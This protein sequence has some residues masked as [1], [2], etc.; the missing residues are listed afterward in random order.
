LKFNK[1]KL[2]IVAIIP[3]RSGSKSIKDKNIVPFKGKPLVAWSILHCLKC[4]VFDA[5]YFSTDSKRYGKI[6]KSYGIKN[7]LIR[8]KNISN[9]Q[10]TDYDFINHFIKTVKENFDI[11]AHIRPTTPIRNV[12]LTK[13]ILQFFIKNK[14]Y[15]SLRSVH[16]NS[17]TAYKSFEIK[18][19]LLKP[20]KFLNFSI[21]EL[22]NPRQNFSKT[23]SANGYIDLYRKKFIIKNKKL[24][25]KKVYAF[26]TLYTME[27]DN[28][29]QLDIL[30]KL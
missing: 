21:N 25:G 10:S 2:K 9:D 12:K 28:K 23:Y 5:I 29:T 17:E 11:I 13:K 22:N 26:K 24:F 16:E 8:P 3:A 1:N 19:N 7:I 27:I 30:K 4:N 18:N 15:D 6:A 20:L 14:Q